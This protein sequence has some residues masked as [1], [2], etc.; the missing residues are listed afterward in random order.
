[1]GFDGVRALAMPAKNLEK[2][3]VIVKSDKQFFPDDVKLNEA[4]KHQK[5]VLDGNDFIVE[6]IDFNSDGTVNIYSR[7]LCSIRNIEP[8]KT[9]FVKYDF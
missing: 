1:M 6:S 9:F 7:N 4:E 5:D 8:Y 2:G 3:N